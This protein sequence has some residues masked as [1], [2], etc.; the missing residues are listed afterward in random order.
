MKTFKEFL[1]ES[2]T[3]QNAQDLGNLISGAKIINKSTL[4]IDSRNVKDLVTKLSRWG[5]DMSQA[6]GGDVIYKKGNSSVGISYDDAKTK[7]TVTVD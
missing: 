6:E 5:Y 3:I 2:I 4:Q 1:S 7:A